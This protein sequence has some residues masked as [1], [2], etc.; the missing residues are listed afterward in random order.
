MRHLES[1][2]RLSSFHPF[3][4]HGVKP[5]CPTQ[6]SLAGSA[7]ESSFRE[8]KHTEHVTA[9]EAAA[10]SRSQ[11]G[12]SPTGGAEPERLRAA[13]RQHLM[14]CTGDTA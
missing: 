2:Q 13:R 14:A 5:D 9:E 10:P 7:Q 3:L 1:K 4:K 11:P 12:C 6:S 8:Q